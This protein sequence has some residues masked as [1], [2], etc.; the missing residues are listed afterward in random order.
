MAAYRGEAAG[1]RDEL[2]CQ[3]MKQASG[4]PSEVGEQL[5]WELLAAC[6]QMYPPR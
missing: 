5:G 4:N 1:L 2:Y 3:L 6:A